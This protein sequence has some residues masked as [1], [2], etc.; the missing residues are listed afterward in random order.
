MSKCGYCGGAE[1]NGDFCMMVE[2]VDTIRV[3]LWFHGTSPDG[4]DQSIFAWLTPKELKH[5]ADILNKTVE[6]QEIVASEPE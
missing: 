3:R 2:R 1:Q 4:E 6:L 5:Y